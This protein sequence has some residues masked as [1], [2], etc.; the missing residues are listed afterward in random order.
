MPELAA[1]MLEV[2]RDARSS[3]KDVEAVIVRDPA[4]SAKILRAANS[5]LYGFS[6][7]IT[8]IEHA[9]GVVG[10][11]Q[12]LSL[13]LSISMFDLFRTRRL[14]LQ[15]FWRH[16]IATAMGAK[17]LAQEAQL[18][19]EVSFMAG[20][21]HDIGKLAFASLWEGAYF[22][23]LR[24]QHQ[25]AITSCEAETRVLRYPHTGAG[26][27]MAENWSL[28]ADYV[29]AIRYHHEPTQAAAE[30]RALCAL[31]HVANFAAHEVFPSLFAH[32]WEEARLAEAQS[33]AQL[34]PDAFDRCMA[35][36]K[37]QAESINTFLMAIQ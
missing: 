14:D 29:Q 23:V 35:H 36:L 10:F 22:R 33:L 30:H 28:P 32:V 37:E 4:L 20:L 15:G 25:E 34:P 26:G 5:A 31:V 11:N 12:I 16:S 19:T 27:V 24:L 3:A 9:I 21:L 2:V 7:E 17:W 8:T 13:S 18:P 1:R 6:Q